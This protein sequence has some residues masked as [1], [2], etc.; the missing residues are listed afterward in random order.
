MPNTVSIRPYS[1]SR[2]S[3]E[4][5]ALNFRTFRDSVPPDEEIDDLAFRV[6]HRWLMKTFAPEDPSRN[7]ILVAE[8]DGVYA[9]HCWIGTQTEFF[10]RAIAPWIFDLSVKPEFRRRGVATKLHDAA[11]DHLR[12]T[13]ADRLGLQVMAHNR[14]AA[15]LYEKLGYEVR[16][17]SL[18]RPLSGPRPNSKFKM[19]NSK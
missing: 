14:D 15:K 19:G 8:I 13:G 1:H 12:K 10:T 6:H 18:T 7:T 17:V 9:G 4:F 11:R 3:K 16:A 2:D 5:L